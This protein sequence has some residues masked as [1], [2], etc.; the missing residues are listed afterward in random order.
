MQFNPF[1]AR[2]YILDQR[3]RQQDAG[4]R[5]GFAGPGDQPVAGRQGRCFATGAAHAYLATGYFGLGRL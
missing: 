3:G 4:G 1:E 5:N 2:R